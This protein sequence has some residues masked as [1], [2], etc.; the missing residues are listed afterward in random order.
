MEPLW[1]LI[2]PY[3]ALLSLPPTS[4]T[5]IQLAEVKACPKERPYQALKELITPLK[6]L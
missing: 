6:A 2:E 5:V 3:G 1:S 4:F